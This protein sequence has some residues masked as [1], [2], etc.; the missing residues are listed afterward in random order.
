MFSEL[1]WGQIA[2]SLKLSG[3]ELQ[4]VR[5]I[6]DDHIEAAIADNLKVSPHTVHTHCERLYRKLGVTGRV[7]LALRVMDEY[8]ALTLAPGTILPPLCASFAAGRCPL[9]GK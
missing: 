2:R 3:Q 4:V 1:A 5:G 7:R 8:I 6:F 9:R